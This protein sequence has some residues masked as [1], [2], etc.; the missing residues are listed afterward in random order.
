LDPGHPLLDPADRFLGDADAHRQLFLAGG[1][2]GHALHDRF[3]DH[4]AGNLVLQEQ[5]VAVA[6][7]GPDPGQDR[8][9]V[10]LDLVEKSQKRVHVEDRLADREFS[11]RFDLL[12]E[13]IEFAPVI[14]GRGIEPHADQGRGLRFDGLAA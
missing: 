9:A 12:P 2:R 10:N 8:D 1:D 4:D 14:Q 13:T 5:G 11:P 7:Q 3:G 6:G